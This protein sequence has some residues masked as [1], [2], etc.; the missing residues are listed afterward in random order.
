MHPVVDVHNIQRLPLS[1]RRLA[2]ATCADDRSIADLRRLEKLYK[3]SSESQKVCFLPLFFISLDTMLIP[4]SDELE[5]LQ[6]VTRNR[7]AC[8]AFCLDGIF[9]AAFVMDHPEEA[10]TTLWPRV[11]P[12]LHFIDQHRG[13]LPRSLVPYTHYRAF[14]LFAGM[15]YHSAS[16]SAIMSSTPNFRAIITKGWRE[17][18]TLKEL[19]APEPFEHVICYVGQFL[20]ILDLTDPAHFA[21]IIDGAGGTLD[22][23]AQLVMKYISHIL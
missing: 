23:L 8:A 7:V 4:T 19:D 16:I 12:W 11:W 10:G 15:V 14:L 21:E 13:H 3:S 2:L 9:Q 20:V 1:I 6:P 5:T 17:L 18:P 22:D